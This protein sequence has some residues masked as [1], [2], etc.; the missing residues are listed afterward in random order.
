VDWI[1]S[2]QQKMYPYQTLSWATRLRPC[3][4]AT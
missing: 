2:D 3:G 1:G 4:V